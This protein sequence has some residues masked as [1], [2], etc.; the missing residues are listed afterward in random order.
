MSSFIYEINKDWARGNREILG[1]NVGVDEDGGFLEGYSCKDIKYLSDKR[2][3][4]M[5]SIVQ[6]GG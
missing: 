2:D 6:C 5:R 1:T 3:K 4:I